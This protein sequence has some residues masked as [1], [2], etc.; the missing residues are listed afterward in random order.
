M[1]KVPRGGRLTSLPEGMPC[2]LTP[3]RYPLP[4]FSPASRRFPAIYQAIS[5]P[6]PEVAH[7]RRQP[8]PPAHLAAHGL[9]TS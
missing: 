9:P 8:A 1:E 7:S 3:P 4:P 5:C 6:F 2:V